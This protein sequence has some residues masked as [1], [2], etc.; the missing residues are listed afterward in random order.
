MS[1]LIQYAVVHRSA[2]PIRGRHSETA[3]LILCWM[4]FLM[5]KSISLAMWASTMLVH[6]QFE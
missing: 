2:Y 6:H 5:H 4:P 3:F 1:G